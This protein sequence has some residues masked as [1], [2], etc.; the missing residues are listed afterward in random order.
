MLA[1]VARAAAAVDAAGGAAVPL[2]ALVET[3]GALREVAGHRRTPAHRVAVVRADGLR[4]GAPRRHPASAM[5][6]KG[7]FE[8][9]LVVRAKLEIAAACHRHGKVPSHCV[10]TEFKHAMRRCRT[11]RRGPAAVRLHAHV[12]HPPGADPPIVEAFTPSVAEVDQAVEIIQAAQAAQLG[13][14]P[15]PR[16]AA[17]PGQLPLLLADHRPGASHVLHRR[18]AVA[19]RGA[20]RATSR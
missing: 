14:D 20:R 4:V 10:V 19:G 9:P 6:V 12:E 16:H 8:H 15:A 2:H 11:R 18:P 3:H 7:Q 1:D 17:R 5:G 13:A